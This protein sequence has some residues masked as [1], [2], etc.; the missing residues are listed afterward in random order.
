[1]QLRCKGVKNFTKISRS[2][3]MFF[4]KQDLSSCFKIEEALRVHSVSLKGTSHENIM[5]GKWFQR[6]GHMSNLSKLGRFLPM[7]T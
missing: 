6:K 3:F 7:C 4:D 1:V 2:S 5:D